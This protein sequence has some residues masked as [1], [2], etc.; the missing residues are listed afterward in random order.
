[1]ARIGVPSI[2]ASPVPAVSPAVVAPALAD[3]E[4]ER[5]ALLARYGLVESAIAALTALAPDGSASAGPAAAAPRA[6]ALEPGPCPELLSP[7]APG[8]DTCDREPSDASTSA[9]A[10]TDLGHCNRDVARTS[11]ILA[12]IREKP[13]S[14]GEIARQ[15][16]I[17]RKVAHSALWRLKQG[18][19]LEHHG[20]RGGARWH[21]GPK[22]PRPEPD[23]EV[24][25]KG[26]DGPLGP[27]YGTIDGRSAT[28]SP[29]SRANT[30]AR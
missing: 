17:D 20:I 22:A 19:I 7:G 24:S 3:L 8:P 25:W 26:S 29:L 5:A 15:L 23:L 10:V 16:N 9:P 18:G 11:A 30:E 12:L 2:G 6:A 14:T 27:G 1:M 28:G 4:R 21:L 13:R